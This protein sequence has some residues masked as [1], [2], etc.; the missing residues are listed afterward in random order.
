MTENNQVTE[1]KQNLSSERRP[2]LLRK[3]PSDSS[4]TFAKEEELSLS[5]ELKVSCLWILNKSKRRN[6]VKEMPC[7]ND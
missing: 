6:Q 4:A 5:E 3:S 1:D 2:R 7:I